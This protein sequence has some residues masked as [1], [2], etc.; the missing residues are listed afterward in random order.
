[1]VLLKVKTSPVFIV[2]M[3]SRDFDMIRVKRYN[4]L[5]V[6]FLDLF[7]TENVSTSIFYEAFS[8]FHMIIRFGEHDYMSSQEVNLVPF[9]CVKLFVHD[10]HPHNHHPH[11]HH[12]LGFALSCYFWQAGSWPSFNPRYY[13]KFISAS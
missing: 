4:R 1:M 7:L 12:H 13:S 8:T 5:E 2:N 6:L 9:K 10:Y 3:F 11:H